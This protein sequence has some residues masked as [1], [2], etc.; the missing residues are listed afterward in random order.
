MLDI[1]QDSS[2]MFTR[3]KRLPKYPD[4]HKRPLQEV[5]R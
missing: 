2:S 5:A 1:E 4:F 3:N